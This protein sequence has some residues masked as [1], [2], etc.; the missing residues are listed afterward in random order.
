MTAVFDPAK[1]AYYEKQSSRALPRLFFIAL[2]LSLGIA[3][4]ADPNSLGQR[5]PLPDAVSSAKAMDTVK[6]IY[7]KQ[8]AKARLPKERAEI[9]RAILRDSTATGNPSERYAMLAASLNLAA[10]G[11]NVAL[12]I[13]VVDALDKQ[14]EVDRISILSERLDKVAGDV[15][16]AAWT[17]ISPSLRGAAQDATA[18]GRFDEA[19][20][21]W[22]AYTKLAKRAGDGKA[23]NAAAAMRKQLA[24]QKKEAAQLNEL[25]AAAKRGDA[26]P[27]D[28]EKLGRYM[29]FVKGEWANGLPSLAKCDSADLARVAKLELEA[30]LDKT[31]SNA[32]QVAEAWV[33]L[34]E[35]SPGTDRG[36]ILEHAMDLYL[37]AIPC[38]EGLAKVKA[39][40]ALDELQKIAGAAAKGKGP[41][42]VT[43]F[44]SD[45]SAIWNTDTNNGPS[46]YA[47]PLAGLPETVR[48]LRMRRT[49]GEA[50]IIAANRAAV[51]SQTRGLRYGW[52]GGKPVLYEATLLG[53]FDQTENI[54]GE[55]G[56]SVYGSGKEYYS[57]YGFGA[58]FQTV[59]PAVAVWKGK[60]IKGEILEISVTS[61]LLS[62]EDR[63]FLLE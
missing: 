63:Q 54:S 14:F 19:D 9:A 25:I 8:F 2:G 37:L 34:A 31:P 57:G 45:S 20:A 18:H 10:M 56:V 24:Q 6:E 55:P 39:Q 16:A 29:C 27:A 58:A 62:P 46:R 48:Y 53:I 7:A 41:A 12:L 60:A 30:V 21:I 3:T 32:L 38:L 22:A 59:G 50:V 51:S 1:A 42:W 17:K 40:K 33:A 23:A 43:I 49:N 13:E 5:S 61:L 44:K 15:P 11:D 52:Q 28:F 26:L 36:A 47:M 4:A 35:G